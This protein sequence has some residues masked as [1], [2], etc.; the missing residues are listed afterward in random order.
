MKDISFRLLIIAYVLLFF[1][2]ENKN[3]LRTVEALN[4]QAEQLRIELND[5]LEQDNLRA[6]FSNKYPDGYLF[7]YDTSSGK[8]TY[9]VY[10][11]DSIEF[12]VSTWDSVFLVIE[13]LK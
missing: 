10:L 6:V 13:T 8:K 3:H 5:L 7:I 2:H 12:T 1:A 9:E 11:T 4:V